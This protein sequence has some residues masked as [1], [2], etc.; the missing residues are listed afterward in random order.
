MFRSSLQRD[1][2]A[3]VEA[4]QCLACCFSLKQLKVLNVV[5][6]HSLRE[7]ALHMALRA[8]ATVLLALR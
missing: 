7:Y 1:A 2:A 6:G 3:F 4:V 5:A 8:L